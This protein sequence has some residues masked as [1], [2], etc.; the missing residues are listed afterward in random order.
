MYW[1]V[2]KDVTVGSRCYVVLELGYREY[3]MV[4]GIL[5]DRCLLHRTTNR[6]LFGYNLSGIAWYEASV[7]WL[8]M[9]PIG[10]RSDRC[11]FSVGVVGEPTQIFLRIFLEFNA[12]PKI[13]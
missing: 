4:W 11:L 8:P 12:L 7:M 3:G 10:I 1:N 2:E 5:V 13:F 9:I 6:N